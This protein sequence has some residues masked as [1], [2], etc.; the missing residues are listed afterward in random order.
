MQESPEANLAIV[1]DFVLMVY[2]HYETECRYS[3][4]RMSMFHTKSQPKM[5]GKA[6][7]IKDFGPVMVACWRTFSNQ[8]LVLHQ[9]ILYVLEGLMLLLK[10]H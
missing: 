6:A 8:T 9:K 5:R 7:E 3:Q 1:W 4:I 2:D 10:K